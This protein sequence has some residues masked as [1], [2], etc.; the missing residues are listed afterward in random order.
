MSA[1]PRLRVALVD[2]EPLALRGLER[3][4]EREGDCEV[5]A[6]CHDGGSA[7]AA[8]R[9]VRPHV[10]FLDV[11]MPGG[12]GFEVVRQVGI[13][14]MPVTV[15]ITAF[16]QFAVRAF[17]VH[18]IDYLLKPFTDERFAV[19]VERARQRVRAAALD[20]AEARLGALLAAVAAAAP[21]APARG[22]EQFAI[23]EATR[24]RFVAAGD[25]EW[26]EG[27]DYYV[28][29]HAAGRAHLLRETLASLEARLDRARFVRVHRSAIVNLAYVRELRASTRGDGVVVLA[30][31]A[32][33]RLSRAKRS[34]VEALL[35]RTRR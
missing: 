12:D 6:R 7:V 31:G 33:V 19:A 8:I 10:V 4:L 29:L 17:D 15:F 27:A 34:E 21:P 24:V 18:A 14:A 1:A 9:Q 13:A 20:D 26:I 2:D 16:D 28:K 32:T 22:I 5:V 11:Q 25:V 23:R 3:L 30:S 35:V